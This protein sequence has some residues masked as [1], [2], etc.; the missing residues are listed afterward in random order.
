MKL[1][2]KIFRNK[3]NFNNA[4]NISSS[5]ISKKENSYK[6]EK[7]QK[8]FNNLDIK[9]HKKRNETLNFFDSIYYKWIPHKYK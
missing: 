1:N 7:I 5:K 3:K 8:N 6:N 4:M 2:I 9:K